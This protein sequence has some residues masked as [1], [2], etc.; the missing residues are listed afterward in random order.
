MINIH[1]KFAPASNFLLFSLAK[2]SFLFFSLSKCSLFLFNEIVDLSVN[3]QHKEMK[4]WCLSLLFLGGGGEMEGV[5]WSGSVCY[6]YRR[7][8]L[9]NSF[10]FS[11]DSSANVKHQK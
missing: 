1:I 6:W 3:S 5:C 2:G 4:D 7:E 9:K 8:S 11:P 10:L